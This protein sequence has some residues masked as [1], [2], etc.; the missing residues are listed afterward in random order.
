M[1]LL[2]FQD[3]GILTDGKAKQ[4]NGDRQK[5]VHLVRGETALYSEPYILRVLQLLNRTQ[6]KVLVD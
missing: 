1:F 5:F 6:L 2:P 3:K 4:E